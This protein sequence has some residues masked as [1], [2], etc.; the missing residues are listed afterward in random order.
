MQTKE[1]F[2]CYRGNC[3]EAISVGGQIHTLLEYSKS[4]SCFYA[5]YSLKKGE[6]F[7]SILHQVFKTVKVVILL[8]SENFFNNCFND[9]DIVLV[10]LQEALKNEN[11]K[12]LP[13]TFKNFNYANENLSLFTLDEIDRFKHKS[14]FEYY[15]PYSFDFEKIVQTICDLM[16]DNVEK[17]NNHKSYNDTIKCFM[18]WLTS[19]PTKWGTYDVS[20]DV[21]ISNTCEGVLTMKAAG[22]DKIK[23]SIYKKALQCLLNTMTEKGLCSKSLGRETVIHTSMLLKIASIE[24]NCPSGAIDD[25][26]IF[27]LIAEN[28]WESRNEESGW[29][30]YIEQAEDEDCS[31]FNTAWALHALN[32]YLPQRRH[33]YIDFLYQMFEKE[34]DGTFGFFVGGT[35]KLIT[36]SMY[37]DLYYQMD[38]N[39]QNEIQK[40]F[41]IK[42]CVNYVY[43]ELVK[44]NVQVEME[45]FYDM[46]P[47]LLGASNKK[48]APW[49]HITIDF[50][51]KSLAKAFKNG[52]LSLEQ[53]SNLLEYIDNL[54]L[55]QI[56]DIGN[57]RKAYHP[58]GMENAKYG[59]YTFPT[60]HFVM[61]LCEIESV[62]NQ[63]NMSLEG[64]KHD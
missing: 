58:M 10:E 59:Q 16:E 51:L 40:R 18:Q 62:L 29:G 38:V 20:T 64:V 42:K 26:T 61:G 47:P 43:E 46:V 8:L 33:E 5:P 45:T 50:T 55:K 44:H 27:N 28:L 60:F 36:T 31:M 6:D 12:F 21:Q 63:F 9:D 14:A 41:S 23:P 56:V 4:I 17:L 11:L 15:T 54:L 37:L 19:L 13:I 49:N 25:F 34:T 24:K 7:K 53:M 22:Y 3:Q 35:P 1:V 39:I 57:E 32:D 2:I 52:E 30:L 48:R